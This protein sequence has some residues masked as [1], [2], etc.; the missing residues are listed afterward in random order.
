MDSDTAAR[1][2]SRTFKYGLSG[3]KIER[4]VAASNTR[5]SDWEGYGPE[6]ETRREEILERD[7]HTCRRCFRDKGHLQVHHIVPKSEGGSEADENLITLCRPCH[8]VQHPEN[9][10][11]DDSRPKATLYPDPEAPQPVAWMQYP[12]HHECERCETELEDCREIIAFHPPDPERT[13]A[14][15][16]PCAGCLL[17]EKPNAKHYL[18][19][20]D[21]LR[22]S[23]LTERASEAQFRYELGAD[24]ILRFRRDPQ[25]LWEKMYYLVPL[26]GLV[27][28]ALAIFLVIGLL[29][30]FL[31]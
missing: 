14:L 24:S 12:Q 15:C 16:K 13:L 11:F 21:R 28:R 1:A 10:A 2:H 6:W 20:Q 5:S 22:L 30:A 29:I 4:V 25:N 26:W 9:P 19:A 23:E 17:E 31:F 3:R 7:G 18:T 8:A 27:W